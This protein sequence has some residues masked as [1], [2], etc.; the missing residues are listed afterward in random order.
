MDHGPHDQKHMQVSA[1]YVA[2]SGSADNGY[3]SCDVD[4]RKSKESMTEQSSGSATS[5]EVSE[6]GTSEQRRRKSNQTCREGS[7]H[8]GCDSASNEKK[9]FIYLIVGHLK[10]NRKRRFKVMRYGF[11][12]KDDIWKP[13]EGLPRSSVIQ[14]LKKKHKSAWPPPEALDQ[15][16]SSR[17][18]IA[19]RISG[20]AWLRDFKKTVVINIRKGGGGDGRRSVET[21]AVVQRGRSRV[22][23]RKVVVACA[24]STSKGGG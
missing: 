22:K 16:R 19:S 24:R 21:E 17:N 13:I 4:G 1:T 11:P 12:R 6:G 2:I 10:E 3:N 7:R 8:G 5:S 14:C 18:C 20:D 9:C 23:I 15:G